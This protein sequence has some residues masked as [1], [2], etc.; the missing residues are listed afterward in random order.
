MGGRK[1]GERQGGVTTRELASWRG[2]DDTCHVGRHTRRGLTPP[3]PLFQ[4]LYIAT[5]DGNTRQ[6]DWGHIPP[7][8]CLQKL[9]TLSVSLSLI[10]GSV[11][12]CTVRCFRPCPDARRV[13]LRCCPPVVHSTHSARARVECAHPKRHCRHGLHTESVHVKRCFT[14]TRAPGGLS[15]GFESNHPVRASSSSWVCVFA[16]LRSCVSHLISEQYSTAQR[17]AHVSTGHW[18]QCAT[19]DKLTVFATDQKPKLLTGGPA[20]P[21]ELL[22]V[23]TSVRLDA[24]A[25]QVTPSRPLRMSICRSRDHGR[26]PFLCMH[27]RSLF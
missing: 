3:R 6:E 27:A 8:L 15:W 5:D 17:A 11:C 23:G 2:D 18:A 26:V 12:K 16:F 22:D 7:R 25:P 13:L 14:A 21:H 10:S 19:E 24:C 9:S 20:H 4:S 1:Q